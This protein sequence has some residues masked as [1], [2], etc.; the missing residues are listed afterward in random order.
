MPRT[1]PGGDALTSARLL[2]ASAAWRVER[3]IA[4]EY[5]LT[6]RLIS[7]AERALPAGGLSPDRLAA[8]RA[9]GARTQFG[10]IRGISALDP[11]IA[12]G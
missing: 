6:G 5:R 11:G 10:S 8:E 4:L 3:G 7:D 2:G 12:V 1:W 9:R